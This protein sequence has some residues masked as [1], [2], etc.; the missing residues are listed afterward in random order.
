MWQV[1]GATEIGPRMPQP[2]DETRGENPAPNYTPR[3]GYFGDLTLMGGPASGLP[4]DETERLLGRLLGLVSKQRKLRAQLSGL[5]PNKKTFDAE[6][7][8]IRQQQEEV[9]EAIT[10]L[11][12]P[13]RTP[14]Q[15][16]SESPQVP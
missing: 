3:S 2:G 13:Q 14:K 10:R 4:D 9:S 12:A 1:G 11:L 8:A 7:E 16:T 6:R 15:S 5:D